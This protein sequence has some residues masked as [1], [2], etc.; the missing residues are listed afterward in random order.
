MRSGFVYRPNWV[1]KKSLAVRCVTANEIKIIP[2]NG[3]VNRYRFLKA[4]E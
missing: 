1:K 3:L 2:I 4:T